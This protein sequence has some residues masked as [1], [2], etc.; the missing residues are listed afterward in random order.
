VNHHIQTKRTTPKNEIEYASYAARQLRTDH[1][2]RLALLYAQA[3]T[4]SLG[5]SESK[6]DHDYDHDYDHDNL[7]ADIVKKHFMIPRH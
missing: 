3:D 2:A 5:R 4:H 1:V 6:N 7:L